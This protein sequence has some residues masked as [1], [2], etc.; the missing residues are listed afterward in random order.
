MWVSE[1]VALLIFISVL[2][3]AV[4][5]AWY[6]GP[7][8]EYQQGRFHTFI[9][10][11]AGLA[12]FITFLFYYNLI[13]LQGQ[14][15]Q[16]AVVQETARINDSVLNS[17]LDEIKDASDI[18]PNFVLSITPLTNAICCS[19]G[20]TGTTGCNISVGPDPV[21]PQSCTE[22]AVLSYRIFAL[23]SDIIMS[24]ILQKIDQTSY[25][26][27]FLQRANSSQLYVQWTASSLNFSAQTQSFG[28]L[29]FEYGLPITIQTPQEYIA[30]AN[31]LIADPRF[32]SIFDG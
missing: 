32:K 12:I 24:N 22:K 14:Q 27:N 17:V 6:L 26:S 28:N 7:H 1:N 8:P 23:W 11:L 2:V 21:D 19:T 16:F 18:I 9:V 31:K 5:L 3:V 29:L 30:V 10:I 15:Q 25:V 4:L 13:G 20:G